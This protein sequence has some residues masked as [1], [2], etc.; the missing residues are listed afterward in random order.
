MNTSGSIQTA[1]PWAEG[2]QELTAPL[3]PAPPLPALPAGFMVRLVNVSMEYSRDQYR[4][5][6]TLA[7]ARAEAETI[8][9]FSA[10]WR[11][12]VTA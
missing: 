3:A 5:F 8:N 11:A 6:P 12:E 7:E 10:N 4:T 9:Q 1:F 2:A